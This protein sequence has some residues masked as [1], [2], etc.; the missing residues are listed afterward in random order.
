MGMREADWRDVDWHEHLRWVEID[1]RQVNVCEVGEGHPLVLVH[2]HSGS[3]T[4]WLANIGYFARS[5]RVIAPDLPG[6]GHSEMPRERISIENY[7]RFLGKLFDALDVGSAPVV[8]NSMGGFV[9]AE[10]AVK[11]PE[12]VE[13]LA[14]VSAAGLSTR[15]IGLSAE[16]LRRKSVRAF[17]RATNTYARIPEARIETLVRR[18]RLRSAVLNMIVKD[19][20]AL[21]APVAAEMLK[22]SGRPAS[23]FAMDAIM[24]YDFRDH[25]KQIRCPALIVWGDSDRVV[26]VEGAD[27]YAEAVP[28]ARKVIL[29]DTGHVPMIERPAEFN[30]L[31]DEFLAELPRERSQPAASASVSR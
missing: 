17:A 15:Y 25:A 14:L 10:L 26:P 20:H 19:P 4:N 27:A 2:G 29:P 6:F 8:G 13:G 11:D 24:D 3:W 28:H 23:P 16:L 21:P 31:I 30:R 1:G 7:A 5:H 22:G 12:R 9:G 18:P